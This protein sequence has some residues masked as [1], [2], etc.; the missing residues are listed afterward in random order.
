M[1]Q[2]K[3]LHTQSTLH[4]PSVGTVDNCIC[5]HHAN[6]QPSQR[7]TMPCFTS[8][9]PFAWK[10]A[11]QSADDLHKTFL[12][13]HQNTHRIEGIT[14]FQLPATLKVF[15]NRSRL[16]FLQT[17]LGREL[18]SRPLF[19]PKTAFCLALQTHANP[20]KSPPRGYQLLASGKQC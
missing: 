1:T 18:F 2:E 6:R 3:A 7:T 5:L 15:C 17:T 19:C 10:C 20:A 4:S 14:A 9:L 11:C 8:L 12:R 16:F 13:Q